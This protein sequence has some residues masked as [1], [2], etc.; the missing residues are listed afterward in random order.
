MTVSKEVIQYAIHKLSN[1][2]FNLK[3]APKETG[4]CNEFPMP[5]FGP[6]HPDWQK[7]QELKRQASLSL[8][9]L[10]IF[11]HFGGKIPTKA[12]FRKAIRAGHFL[13]H[14]PAGDKVKR[15]CFLFEAYGMLQSG[16]PETNY[17]EAQK[18]AEHRANDAAKAKE[19]KN[20]VAC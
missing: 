13:Q 6:K 20:A 1:Q 9:A 10:A 8:T 5:K 16:F 7:Y 11:K 3:Q 14:C 17:S 15:N 19:A 4:G 2:I 18:Y 12:D